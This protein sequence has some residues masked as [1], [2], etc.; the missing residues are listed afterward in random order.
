MCCHFD[1]FLVN[2]SSR[3]SAAL[4]HGHEVGVTACGVPGFNC[5]YDHYPNDPDFDILHYVKDK[6][7]QV[8]YAGTTFQCVEYARRWWVLRRDIFLPNVPWASDIWAMDYVKRLSDNHRVPLRKYANHETTER[9]AVGDLLIWQVSDEQPYGHVAVVVEVDDK[10]VR[11]AE[12][13][14]ENNQPWS[15]RTY[16]RQFPLRCDAKT[17]KWH[18]YDYAHETEP[19]FG[20]VRADESAAYPTPAFQP[21][22][23]AR[24]PVHGQYDEATILALQHFVDGHFKDGKDSPVNDYGL[25]IFLNTR[26]RLHDYP[27]VPMGF[28]GSQTFDRAPITKK[29]Q[30]FLNSYPEISGC[31]S[32]C[33]ETRVPE[34]GK[35][36]EATTRGVQN[37]L[38]KVYD[39]HDFDAAVEH[40]RQAVQA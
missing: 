18:I 17:G 3:F 12:Q 5:N 31:H 19:F 7:G 1:G 33:A 10:H 9:P 4:P 25:A 16:S 30:R 24:L 14:Y 11:I 20:W 34:T 21:P 13:N 32:N 6:R 23:E 29:L 38:N 40:Y 26:L 8:H 35:W 15:G 37:L 39:M 36:C 2:L 28:W 27:H 22:K